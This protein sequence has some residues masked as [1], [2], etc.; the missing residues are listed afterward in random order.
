M[1]VHVPLSERAVWE[2][3]HLML[4]SRNLLKPA[5][6]EPIISPSKDMVMGVF[7]LTMDDHRTNHRGEGRIFAD[8]DEVELAY[9]LQQVEVHSH[10]KM[11]VETWYDEK[12]K[13]M[14]QP[15]KRLQETTVGRVLFN[16][17]LPSKVQFRNTKLDKGGVKDLIGDVLEFCGQEVTTDVAD[18]V[19][20]IGFEYAMRSGSTIA[21]SDIIIPASKDEI[22]TK[23]Q[24][25]V[26]G[27]GRAFRR[28]LLTEQERN[29]RVV[30]I[31]KL[32]T[33]VVAD[34]VRKAMDPNGNLST[35]A[36]SGATKGGFGP[37]AQLAGMRGLMADPSGRIIRLPIT[38]NF[39]EGLTT[40]EYFISTH[41]AR[42]GLADTALRTADAGYLTRRLVDVAQDIIINEPDCGTDDGIFLRKI[43]DRL[44]G[45]PRGADARLARS[46]RLYPPQHGE[47]PAALQFGH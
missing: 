14:A 12:D 45:P 1:A 15:V 40:L 9:Q 23:S 20:D 16:R 3:R 47:Q 19:K 24:Q 46:L 5:D 33:T 13:R 43:D 31:W 29:E 42:K 8:M 17:I 6:G 25:E 11:N 4:S 7:Y 37:I 28:G 44:F 38:S 30:E 41:G 2:A 10:I 21:V 34:A 26:D 32:T 36:L 39:R 27:V 18:L 35:M 22:I